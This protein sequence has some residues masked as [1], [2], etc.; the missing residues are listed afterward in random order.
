MFSIFAGA[1]QGIVNMLQQKEEV[2]KKEQSNFL[3]RLSRSRYSPM[4][5]LSDDEY[6]RML[7]EKILRVDVD[8]ALI[9]EKIEK[10]LEMESSTDENGDL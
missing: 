5:S 6:A 7:R 10:L 1:G 8:I 2:E 4:T 3:Q 9:D